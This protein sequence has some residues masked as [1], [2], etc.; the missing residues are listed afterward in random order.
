MISKLAAAVSLFVCVGS[1]SAKPPAEWQ[2][3]EWSEAVAQAET[4]KKPLFVLF[5]Y[6]GC[7][8]CE[9]LYRR[10]M[11]DAALRAKYQSSAILTYIDT[12]SHRPEE[13]F[14]LPGGAKIAHGELIKRFQAY[15]TPSWIFLS[16]NGATLGSNRSGKTTA[17]EMLRDV[18][19]ALAKQ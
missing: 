19:Q 1:S 8:W 7:E 6:E 5:G 16:S 15:P 3:K 4:E 9:Y 14:T 2:F 11:N 17:R 12:K 18:E 13:E 10:G